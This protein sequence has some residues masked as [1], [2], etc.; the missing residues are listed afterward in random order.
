M[1]VAQLYQFWGFFTIEW[2][3]IF[4]T[5]Y[6]ILGIANCNLLIVICTF[7]GQ[8]EIEKLYHFGGSWISIGYIS[9]GL[10]VAIK[11][12]KSKIFEIA[13]LYLWNVIQGRYVY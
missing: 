3:Y 8:L 13:T 2:Y 6:T 12:P 1:I 10:L 7:L 4:C 11:R 5:N 9:A